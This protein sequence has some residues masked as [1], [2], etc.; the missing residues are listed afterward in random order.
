MD[1]GEG[2]INLELREAIRRHVQSLVKRD[3]V[4]LG[5]EPVTADLAS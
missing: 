2:S 4:T 1:V 3:T 5:V